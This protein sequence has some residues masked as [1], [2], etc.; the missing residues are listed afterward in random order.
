M[1][2]CAP[3]SAASAACFNAVDKDFECFGLLH[4]HIDGGYD[5][6]DH[7]FV[8]HCGFGLLPQ[9]IQTALGETEEGSGIQD[10]SSRA[11]FRALKEHPKEN[12]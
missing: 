10:L 12:A 7:C 9:I 4:Q 5:G 6:I 11:G 2:D 8:A 1:V 3:C